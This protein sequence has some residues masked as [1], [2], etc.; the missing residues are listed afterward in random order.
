MIQHIKKILHFE[1][2]RVHYSALIVAGGTLLNGILSII[3]NSL[4]ASHFGVSTELDAYFAAFRIPD[5]IF[6][7]MI[8]G[9]LSSIFIPSFAKHLKLSKDHAWEFTAKT[10]NGYILFGSLLA[11]MLS[12]NMPI[13]MK[14][15]VPGFDQEKLN[16]TIHLARL[17]LLQPI[18]LGASSLITGALQTLH[19]FLITALAPLLYNIGIITGIVLFSPHYGVSGVVYGVLVGAILHIVFQ[20][21]I[22][23]GSGF[24]YSFRLL[25]FQECM[26]I[27]KLVLPRTLNILLIQLNLVI[28][29]NFI[30]HLTTGSV[31]LFNFAFDIYSYPINIATTSLI[32]ASYPMLAKNF[33]E[34]HE[35]FKE[36]FVKTFKNIILLTSLF[37]FMFAF[38]G[39]SIVKYALEYGALSSSATQTIWQV[40]LFLNVGIIASALLPYLVRIS[41][42]LESTTLPLIT[43]S[44]NTILYIILGPI[45]LKTYGLAG[46]AL[47]LSLSLWCDVIL[48]GSILVYRIKNIRR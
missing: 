16:L 29:M 18:L 21:I 11:V 39:Q 25:G 23:F 19:K 45:F 15:L 32:M 31:S 40:L 41:F 8:T 48:L 35:R 2:E 5:L 42:I 37:F 34:S 7:L 27:L 36:L 14:W 12:W 38:L 3:R 44:L 22:L 10:M 47:A 9:A 33:L 4:L 6:V 43:S 20:S 30:S 13:L 46:I 1:S 24:R 28:T 17:L 26:D